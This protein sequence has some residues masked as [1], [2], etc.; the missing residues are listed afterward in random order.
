VLNKAGHLVRKLRESAVTVNT[1]LTATF[2]CHLARGHY[3]FLVYAVDAA[4]NAQTTIGANTLT[5]R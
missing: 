2:V 4:G 5:V 1:R 3:H